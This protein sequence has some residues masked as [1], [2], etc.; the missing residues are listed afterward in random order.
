M[1]NKLFFSV[2]A[3]ASLSS[4]LRAVAVSYMSDD[5]LQCFPEEIPPLSV[6]SLLPMKL[7]RSQR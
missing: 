6:Y 7:S 5:G 4:S 1:Q 2:D 3:S